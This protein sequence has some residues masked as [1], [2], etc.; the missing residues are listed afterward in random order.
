M[1]RKRG[2]SEVMTR[3]GISELIYD[4]KNQTDEATREQKSSHMACTS[5][6]GLKRSLSQW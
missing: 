1:D 5:A 2:A 6:S 3:G 4:I